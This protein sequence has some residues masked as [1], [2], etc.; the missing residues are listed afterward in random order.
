MSVSSKM[1]HS[2]VNQLT[3]FNDDLKITFNE[4]NVEF[5]SA[6]TDGKMTA[7][8]QAEDLDSYAIPEST[9]LTQTYSLRYIHMMAAFNKLAPEM[10]LGFSAELPMVMKYALG[11]NNDEDSFVRIHLAPK[12]TDDEE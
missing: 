6:G 12:I 3:I 1:F 10:V 11:D 7:R 2:L 8:I 9:V 5:T 4:E